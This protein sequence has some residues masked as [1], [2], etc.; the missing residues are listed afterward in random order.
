MIDPTILPSYSTFLGGSGTDTGI[1]IAVDASGSAYVAG[2]TNSADF[3]VTQGAYQ[4]TFTNDRS[5]Y[6]TDVF[7]TKLSPDGTSLV[8]ST[9]ISG[10]GGSR[11]SIRG[12][13][14]W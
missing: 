11:A 12:R 10:S 9:Y 1:G 7:V 8:Y 5:G 14:K 3:P 13:R 6:D 4:T 2:I